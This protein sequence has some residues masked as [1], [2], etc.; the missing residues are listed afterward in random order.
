MNLAIELPPGRVRLWNEAIVEHT[1]QPDRVNFQ[2]QQHSVSDLPVDVL[3][4]LLGSRYC[5]VDLL[6]EIAWELFGETPTGW[7]R[8]QAVCDW[9]HTH[10]RFGYE[11]ARTTKTA[12][13]VYLERNGVCRDFMHLAVTFCRC[14]NIP[15]RCAAGYLGYIDIPPHP[16][17]VD[18]SGWFEAYLDHQWYTFD[19]RHNIPRVGRILMARGR[20]AVDTAF[21]TSFGQANLQRFGVWTAKVSPIQVTTLA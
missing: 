18:F 8:V 4:Y 21:T 1:G 15:A 13:E 2:A 12:S 11:Y 10:I 7:E 16:D 3:I 5:E 9:V 17:P 19:A 6:S 14:L 20:D